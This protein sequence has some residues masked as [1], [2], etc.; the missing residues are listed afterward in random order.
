MTSYLYSNNIR[1][2]DYPKFAEPLKNKLRE[3]AEN[4]ARD[5]NVEIEFVAK[6]HMISS[7]KTYASKQQPTMSAFLNTTGRSNTG[8]GKNPCNTLH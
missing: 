6:T 7:L 5:H 8:T 1:I 4:L 2:F 3:N